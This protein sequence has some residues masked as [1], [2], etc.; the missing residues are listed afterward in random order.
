[1]T[2]T[3]IVGDAGRG[4]EYD[5]SRSYDVQEEQCSREQNNHTRSRPT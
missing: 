3:D 5:K 1:L 4:T 2:G